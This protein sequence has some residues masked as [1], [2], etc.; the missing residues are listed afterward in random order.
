MQ[1]KYKVI[2]ALA[3]ISAIAAATAIYITSS[4][5]ALVLPGYVEAN[6]VYVSAR[7]GGRLTDLKVSQGDHVDRNQPLFVLQQAPYQ[8]QLDAQTYQTRAARHR[9]QDMQKGKRQPY[10]DQ[11]RA[12]ISQARTSLGYLKQEYQRV[13]RLIANNSTSESA[14]DQARAEYKQKKAYLQ[15]LKARLQTYKLGERKKRLAR[16]QARL[17]SEQ[18][19]QALDKWQ[20]EQR[21]V[22]APAEGMVFD[23]YYWPGEQVGKA[24][25]V[26]SLLVQSRIRL[27]FYVPEPALGDIQVGEDVTFRVD[28]HPE[29]FTASITYI[30]PKAQYT[31]PV[32]YSESMRRDLSYK[33]EA[34][35]KSAMQEG[36][37]AGQPVSVV[38]EAER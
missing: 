4:R 22:H 19:R 12:E 8:L 14:Y 20:L 1:R 2:A 10:L 21:K 28:G 6:L 35:I 26:V 27:V 24:R 9:Y 30:A 25:P 13:K 15:Y 36:W 37:H 38:L 23:T 7:E 31:P 32:I 3:G 29:P 34:S 33:V 17:Q 16:Q 5:E 18:A 11:I